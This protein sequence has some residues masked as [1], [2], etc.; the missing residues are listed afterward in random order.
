M[1][2]GSNLTCVRR[3]PIW[4]ERTCTIILVIVLMHVYSVAIIINFVWID[5]INLIM[6]KSEFFK[7]KKKV[8]YKV[9]YI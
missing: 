7:M 3:K 1:V 4:K 5:S 9:I 2:N 8:E 6:D